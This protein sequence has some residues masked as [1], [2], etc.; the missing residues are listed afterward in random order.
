MAS[1]L[2]AAATALTLPAVVAALLSLLVAAPLAAAAPRPHAGGGAAV[3]PANALHRLCAEEFSSA[4]SAGAPAGGKARFASEVARLSA[5][6]SPLAR[7]NASRGEVHAWALGDALRGRLLTAA[8][9]SR[10]PRGALPPP[11]ARREG[12]SPVA[13]LQGLLS[14]AQNPPGGAEAC[15][16][17][18]AE[19]FC[20]AQRVQAGLGAALHGLAGQVRAREGGSTCCWLHA[21]GA[22]AH[23]R[24]W[25]GRRPIRQRC[26]LRCQQAKRCRTWLDLDWRP[27]WH[28]ARVVTWD[29]TLG[30]R[31]LAEFEQSALECTLSGCKSADPSVLSALRPFLAYGPPPCGVG[32]GGAAP[33]LHP[34]RAAVQPNRRQGAA[35]GS[36]CV[37]RRGAM[38]HTAL[39]RMLLR[40]AVVVPGSRRR[41]RG[42]LRLSHARAATLGG[43]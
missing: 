32:P 16:A 3:L 22:R 26:Q 24:S 17:L 43:E 8:A 4:L 30:N 41:R 40:T 25:D 9:H 34:H 33:R 10:A 38:R 11:V 36:A 18:P 21:E 5:S 2:G 12:G 37:R 29:R 1:R 20:V 23:V 39:G 42:G 35:A 31:R 27:C 6:L 15:A 14:A 19:A 7:R 28:M 13:V